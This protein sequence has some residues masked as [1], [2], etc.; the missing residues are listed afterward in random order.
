M[1]ASDILS[2]KSVKAAIK[3]AEA[4]GKGRRVSDGGGLYLETRPTGAGWWRLRY[5]HAG[6]EGMLSLGTYPETGLRDARQKRD[7]ARKLIAA[8]GDPA[9]PEKLRRQNAPKPVRLR[10]WPTLA[11]PALAPLNTSPAIG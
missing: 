2:D 10:P 4:T 3:A 11:C 1:A 9:P 6:R 5:R 7:E 8:G